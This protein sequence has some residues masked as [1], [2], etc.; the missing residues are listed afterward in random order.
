MTKR[1]LKKFDKRRGERHYADYHRKLK[2][3][4]YARQ[5]WFLRNRRL[6]FDG[7]SKLIDRAMP[8]LINES[9]SKLVDVD[10]LEARQ[11]DCYVR[12]M[13]LRNREPEQLV[14]SKFHS[15]SYKAIEEAAKGFNAGQIWRHS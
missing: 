4:T 5:D 1:I 10:D 14:F 3:G 12:N 2:D 13:K 7:V 9:F 8:N 6:I 15:L 11:D